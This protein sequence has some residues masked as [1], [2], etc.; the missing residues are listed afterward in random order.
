MSNV[1][2]T[3]E[4]LECCRRGEIHLGNPVGKT[5]TIASIDTYFTPAP[6]G[7]PSGVLLYITD[8]MGWEVPNARLLADTY[9][10]EADVDVYMPNFLGDMAL[11]LSVLKSGKVDMPAWAKVHNTAPLNHDPLLICH[12]FA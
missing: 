8:A 2:T 3:S 1:N 7:S 10:T 6:S 12:L 9:A 11:S 4:S 5:T